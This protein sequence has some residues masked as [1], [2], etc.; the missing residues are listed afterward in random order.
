MLKK[1]CSPS[2][3]DVTNADTMERRRKLALPP[4]PNLV[5]FTNQGSF[6]SPEE[7]KKACHPKR[8]TR[9]THGLSLPVHMLT[10]THR[11]YRR[12]L[13]IFPSSFYYIH[14]DFGRVKMDTGQEEER[15][16]KMRRKGRED[17]NEKRSW[18]MEGKKREVGGNLSASSKVYVSPAILAKFM[19]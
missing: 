8:I 2:R 13:C 4:H 15:R 11:K 19:F 1:S 12:L 17:E 7:G 5:S 9:P 14:L 6:T 10:K 18:K 16:G 3:Q